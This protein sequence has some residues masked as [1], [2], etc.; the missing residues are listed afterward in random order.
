MP[1]ISLRCAGG[2]PVNPSA[3]AGHELIVLFCPTSHEDAQREIATYLKHA[4]DFAAHD[5]WLLIIADDPVWRGEKCYNPKILDD[6]DREAWVKF[7][8][9]TSYPEG[10]DRADGAVFYFSRGGALARYW[11]G[12]GHVDDVLALLFLPPCERLTALGQADHL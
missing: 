8:D 6:A 1:H 10:L 4:S 5:G 3:F 12:S 9:L 11:Q 2:D 7:R